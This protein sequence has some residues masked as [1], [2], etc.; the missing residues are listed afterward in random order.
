MVTVKEKLFQNSWRK[1]VSW[2]C[3]VRV[4]KLFL[5]F[6]L[7]LVIFI[8]LGQF[9]RRYM[10]RSV[11]NVINSPLLREGTTYINVGHMSVDLLTSTLTFTDPLWVPDPAAAAADAAEM[12]AEGEEDEIGDGNYL[13]GTF[14]TSVKDHAHQVK[15]CDSY[16]PGDSTASFCRQFG[17]H[18]QLQVTESKK[19]NQLI[20]Y[21]IIWKS[22]NMEFIPQSCFYMD[23]A[24]WYGGP[25]LM[26]PMYPIE[27]GTFSW[28]SFVPGFNPSDS[29]SNQSMGPVVERYWIN[30]Q[31]AGIAV[32]NSIALH[33]SMNYKF[34]NKLCFKAVISDHSLPTLSYTVC[35]ASNVRNVHDY[36]RKSIFENPT[37]SP[38]DLIGKP[39]WTTEEYFG[40]SIDQ[41]KY[42]WY[43]DKITKTGFY[44]SQ[45][46]LDTYSSV[47]GD[48][49]VSSIKFPNSHQMFGQM[50]ELKLYVRLKVCMCAS[51]D[52]SYFAEG[53]EK[54]FWLVDKKSKAIAMSSSKDGMVALVDF[55]NPDAVK[56]Y[57]D[58][59]SLFGKD[60][61]IQ[62]FTFDF[63]EIHNLPLTVSFKSIFKTPADYLTK[64][65]EVVSFI[66]Q[67]AIIKFGFQSQHFP[68]FIE[69]VPKNMTWDYNSGLKNVIPNML[70]LG[71]LGFPFI[72]PSAIGGTNYTGT[73][74]ASKELFIR[75]AQMVSYFP[76]MHFSVPPWHYDEETVH[77]TQNLVKHH[78]QNIAPLIK[79]LMK[80]AEVTGAPIIRPVW[81]IAPEDP[82]ALK[83]DCEFLVGNNLLVAPVLD[84]GSTS[85]DIYLPHGSWKDNLNNREIKGAKLYKDFKVELHQIATFSKMKSF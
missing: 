43:A 24:Y 35:K 23:N 45:I 83:I 79:H 73:L 64:S 38:V 33:T 15:E 56:W 81:W 31:G 9:L 4:L 60:Y 70:T 21:H 14:P 22:L 41:Q 69:A 58:K 74:P 66:D 16:D 49:T 44:N 53:K 47:V 76:I 36:M 25:E 30:S 34:E 80:E 46:Q 77:I 6:V 67:N 72:V 12:A 42:L 17:T 39:L 85:R 7:V 8:N 54:G 75:W 84:S 20:C 27:K 71:I 28:T 68:I 61:G 78:Q 57:Q 2:L 48:T 1:M 26:Q 63:N 50:K 5:F 40:S 19:E 11:N 18:V 13:K 59:I 62:A 55:T 52:V 3:K 32:D 65:S 10:P 37:A 51:P 29:Q 82:V